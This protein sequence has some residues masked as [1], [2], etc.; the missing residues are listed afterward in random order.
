MAA[1]EGFEPS[2]T[3]SESVVLPL[4]NPAIYDMLL[5]ERRVYYTKCAQI[6]KPLFKENCDLLKRY[7]GGAFAPPGYLF[8]HIFFRV[9]YLR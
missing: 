6:V 1:G 8:V 3:E 2:Q 7:P 5:R 9:L 4:H